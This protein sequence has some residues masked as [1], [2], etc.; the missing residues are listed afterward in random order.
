RDGHVTGVQTC[1]LPIFSA[2]AEVLIEGGS[3]LPFTDDSP[4]LFAESLLRL[5]TLA[6]PITS[7]PPLAPSLPW[8][9]W[10]HNQPETWPEPDDVRSEERRVG[11]EG[12]GRGA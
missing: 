8:V 7:L 6:P 3:Q 10:D 1:A 9:G 12:R 4:R 5:V 2:T 11:K